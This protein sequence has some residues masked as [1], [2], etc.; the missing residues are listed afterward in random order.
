MAA[1]GGGE[2]FSSSC[3]PIITDPRGRPSAGPTPLARIITALA[4]DRPVAAAS[5]AVVE[6]ALVAAAEVVLA[7]AA[8]AA[9][10]DAAD[11]IQCIFDRTV[12][13][14]PFGL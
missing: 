6:A 5:A 2:D 14:G 9:A 1:A 13:S 7:A 8:V 3:L 12:P 4:P 11:K 10:V